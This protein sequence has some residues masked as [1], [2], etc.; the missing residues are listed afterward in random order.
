MIRPP[1]QA[2]RAVLTA[3][4]GVAALLARP[5]VA[6]PQGASPSGP[7][8]S[9][10]LADGSIVNGRVVKQDDTVVT[11]DT[12]IFGVISIPRDKIT[13]LLSSS[14]AT[15]AAASGGAAG[16]VHWARALTVRGMY[17][18]AVVPGYIGETKGVQLDVKAT[19]RTALASE[20]FRAKSSY[21]KTSPSP[22]SVDESS[23]E[24]LLT[25][26]I[27]GPFHLLSESEVDR[28][29]LQE[30]RYRFTE[31][32]GIGWN[33]VATKTAWVLLAPGIAYTQEQAPDS[34]RIRNVA[35]G[36]FEDANG[37]GMGAYEAVAFTIIDG[38]SVDQNVLA[39]HGFDNSPRLQYTGEVNLI[40]MVT[41]RFGLSI[42]Y[43]R[44]YDSTLPAPIKRTLDE[45]T[46]GIQITF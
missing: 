15:T 39:I 24:L 16:A 26:S 25:R 38:L 35:G 6:R 33:P 40:G 4:L 18:S 23:A 44:R 28:N 43:S 31:H 37:L 12:E 30:I 17:S 2:R 3:V 8:V 13:Q 32:V 21:Q 34:S 42:G 29:Q 1:V 9:L 45:L 11:L 22:A 7:L 36:A 10:K 20:T 19:R 41:K 14:A 5:A 46:S 27:G